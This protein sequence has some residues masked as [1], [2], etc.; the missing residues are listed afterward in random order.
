MNHK[1][2]IILFI[3]SRLLGNGLVNQEIRHYSQSVG[4]IFSFQLQK[5]L[6]IAGAIALPIAF[7]LDDEV[8]HYA[9]NQ[10]FFSNDISEI[11]DIYGHRVGYYAIAG[12]MVI[13]E[14]F[15]GTSWKRTLASL[16]LVAEGVLAGQVVIEV[17]KSVTGRTRPNGA[18][19]K[20]FPSGH[21]GGTF[22]LATCLNTIYGKQIGIPAYTMAAFVASSRIQDDKHYLSDV[23]AGGLIGIMVARGFAKNYQSRWQISPQITP[24]NMGLSLTIML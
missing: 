8:R 6:L 17:L 15:R 18:G 20:S 1:L 10:G 14:T 24:N 16:R 11:G 13:Y 9:Q 2:A 4:N 5:D 19:T 12:G 3:F 21:A 7:S 22:G 23:I